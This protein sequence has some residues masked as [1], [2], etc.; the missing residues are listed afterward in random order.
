MRQEHSAADW[1]IP[2]PPP[3]PPEFHSNKIEWRR[4]QR[5]L[6]EQ[7]IT[8]DELRVQ[9]PAKM[10][11]YATSKDV[12]KVLL[13]KVAAGGGKTHSGV[14]VAQ[15]CARAGMRVLWAADRH[16]LFEDLQNLPHFEARLWYHWLPIHR[17][18][19]DDDPIPTTCRYNE[20]M[21]DWTNKGYKSAQLCKQICSLDKHIQVCPYRVQNKRKEPIIFAMHNHL[22]SGL[23]IDDFDLVIVDELPLKAFVEERKIPLGNIR[24]PGTSGPLD[25]LMK[26]MVALGEYEPHSLSGKPLF[27]KIGDILRDVFAQVEVMPDSL[28]VTPV[29]A[30]PDDV[31]EQPYWYIMDF[32]ETASLEYDAW[33][34]GWTDWV[35]RIRLDKH[36][37]HLSGRKKVW[38]KLPR[39]VI[40]LDFTA[41]RGLYHQI[42]NREIEEF[43]P[44]IKR[45]GKIYQVTGRLNGIGML[46][47][48]EKKEETSLALE[49]LEIAKQIAKGYTGRVGI[50][51]NK[52]IR[53]IFVREF[54]EANVQHFHA[55]RG[56]N[57]LEDV[58]C[59]IVAGNP[60]AN[61]HA[62][63][64]IAAALNPTR[65]A[66]YGIIN[67]KGKKELVF[68]EVEREYS[69]TRELYEVHGNKTPWRK[70]K[71]FW[72][73]HELQVIEESTRG[74][75][76]LQ[77]V[78][79]C[80]PNVW[81][82][83][84]WVLTSTPME[85]SIDGIWD[86]PPIGPEGIFWKAWLR[87]QPWLEE[88]YESGA[89]INAY[90][91][92]EAIGSSPTWVNRAGWVNA[93]ALYE[94][95]KWEL[96]LVPISGGNRKT[97]SPKNR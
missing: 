72:G 1:T 48:K 64:N 43:H 21:R 41:K 79:R 27:D 62:V 60:A 52:P 93:I 91:I 51:C 9:L 25:E 40:A 31:E 24:V 85:E 71:G 76:L 56:T 73:E 70:I 32:L 17:S 28:P 77:A 6:D 95:E 74:D 20:A 35:E 84:A 82:S 57:M 90:T 46:Y 2:E 47:D 55:M 65:I 38:D 83:D 33:R 36:G 86:D 81:P 94:P 15:E 23:S 14:Q 13:V 18:K 66:P 88:Q 53:H 11:A 58:E 78:H 37:L 16:K 54:G 67:E 12:D 96:N 61:Y 59:L 10:M 97:I 63:V 3:M 26:L 22:A 44:L 34:A 42:F 92:A 4:A 50:I 89:S 49:L 39:R 45:I 5:Q 29:I 75:E 68:H 8:L 19:G 87:L 30:S 80:R 69:V 7:T